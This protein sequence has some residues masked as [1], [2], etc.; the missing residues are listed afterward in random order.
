MYTDKTSSAPMR[1]FMF[2]HSFDDGARAPVRD[3][4]PVTLSPD[5]LDALKKEI[6]EAGYAAGKK[7][8]ADDQSQRLNATLSHVG[9][10]LAR[11]IKNAEAARYEQEERVRTAV[12]AVARKVLPDFSR[13]HGLQEIQAVVAGIVGEMTGEPRFVVR[14]HE[15]QFEP[16]DTALKEIAEK[17]GY[18]GK[19]VLV[20]DASIPQD[21]CRIEWADGGIERN[22]EVLWQSI[23][24]TLAPGKE[25]PTTVST[26]AAKGE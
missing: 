9:T 23:G 11:L 24:R 4:R 18:G 1:K 10:Q 17:H 12:L 15:S 3:R 8:G 22:L 20:A 26:D 5:Q 25:F 21:D 2:D 14:V 13:R 19:A 6:Y 7:A 16:I